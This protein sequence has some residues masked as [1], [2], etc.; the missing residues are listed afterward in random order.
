M[1][2]T[3]WIFTSHGLSTVGQEEV[4]VILE[5]LPDEAAL[6]KD[7]FFFYH[8]LFA[9]AAKGTV[10][11]VV[12]SSVVGV[13]NQSHI[14]LSDLISILVSIAMLMTFKHVLCDLE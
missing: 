13:R 1:G 2:R 12:R 5:S 14:W 7:I 4:V 11:A 10:P 3:C 8:H 9:E 6:P